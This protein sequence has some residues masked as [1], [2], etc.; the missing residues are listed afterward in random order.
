MDAGHSDAPPDILTAD[1]HPGD[2]DFLSCMLEDGF[3]GASPASLSCQP[4]HHTDLNTIKTP[5]TADP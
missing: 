2:A 5:H 4:L 1:R 3:V